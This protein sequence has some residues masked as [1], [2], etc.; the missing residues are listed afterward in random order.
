MSCP[1]AYPTVPEAAGCFREVIRLVQEQKLFEDLDHSAKH[2]WI[3][4][5][6]VQGV[7][8]GDPDIPPIVGFTPAESPE[9]IALLLESA[10]PVEGEE[11][12]KRA[13]PWFAILSVVAK[14]L[15]S[16]LQKKLA[17]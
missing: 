7:I 14:L 6:A 1:I 3:V 13:I 12:V 17:A 11:E 9:E 5:G 15:E 8:L 10:L 2:L 4:Q 16:L